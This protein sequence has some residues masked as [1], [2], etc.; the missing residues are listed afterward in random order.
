MI[1]I[2]SLVVA[3]VGVPGTS[4]SDFPE[5]TGGSDFR[6]VPNIVYQPDDVTFTIASFLAL[7]DDTSSRWHGFVDPARIGIGGH[8]FGAMTSMLTVYNTRFGDPDVLAVVEISGAEFPVEG[9]QYEYADR[10]P[11]LLVHGDA[12]PVV[13]YGGSVDIYAHAEAPKFFLTLKGRN[14]GSFFSPDDSDFEAFTT[15]V[16]SFYDFYVK[17]DTTTPL[18]T[19]FD[20]DAITVQGQAS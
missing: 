15:W 12:D 11:L 14:H 20:D 13:G 19:A 5:T 18:V 17:G 2:S 4:R 8:S 3:V 6:A 10:P 16:V 9:G 7:N 1:S